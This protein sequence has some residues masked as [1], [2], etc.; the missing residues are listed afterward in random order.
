[1]SYTTL[2]KAVLSYEI[3][4]GVLISFNHVN[5]RSEPHGLRE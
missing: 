5:M 3:R 1:L 4:S 2:R